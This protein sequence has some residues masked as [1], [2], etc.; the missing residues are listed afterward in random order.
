MCRSG[1][2]NEDGHVWESFWQTLAQQAAGVNG[3]T[4]MK[5]PSGKSSGEKNAR[6]RPFG[7]WQTPWLHKHSNEIETKRSADTKTISP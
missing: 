2:I 3:P 7:V 6:R 1:A 4:E 5:W